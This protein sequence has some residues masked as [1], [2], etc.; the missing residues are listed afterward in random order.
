MRLFETY[1]EMIQGWMG[2]GRANIL[3]DAGRPARYQKMSTKIAQNEAYSLNPGE[4]SPGLVLLST[5][6][7]TEPPQGGQ[8]T[9]WAGHVRPGVC[10]GRS[11][12]SRTLPGIWSDICQGNLGYMSAQ[13]Q[14]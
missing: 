4:D 7:H 5:P 6:D 13:I 12:M 11:G 10:G 2:T 8:K 9:K 14:L 3:S 1:V